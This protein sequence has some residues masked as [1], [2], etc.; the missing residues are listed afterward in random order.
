[1]G[2]RL[3]TILINNISKIF[4]SVSNIV[5]LDS[6]SPYKKNILGSSKYFK[7]FENAKGF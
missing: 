3:I 2:N 5:N 4:Q 6:Y 1:M 7:N